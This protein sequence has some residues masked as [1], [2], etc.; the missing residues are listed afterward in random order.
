MISLGRFLPNWL[1]R[2]AALASSVAS[3]AS[4]WSL[5]AGGIE[6]QEIRWGPLSLFRA[7]PTLNLDHLSLQVGITLVAFTAI[8]VLSLRGARP[9]G[10]A[11]HGLI[12]IALSGSLVVVMAA[13]TLTA[14][15]GSALIDLAMLALAVSDSKDGRP[16]LASWKSVPGLL[17]TLF[18]FAAA[19]RMDSQVGTTSLL[20]RQFPTQVVAMVGLAGFLRLAVLFLHGGAIHR[21]EH[22]ATLILPFGVGLYLLV[23]TQAIAPV[24]AALPGWLTFAGLALLAGG[25]LAW[26]RG[27]ERDSLGYMWPGIVFHQAGLA[28]AF[29]I[30]L[31]GVMPWPLISMALATGIVAVWWDSGLEREPTSRSYVGQWLYR[32]VEPGW[33][34][35]RS[36][37]RERLPIAQRWPRFWWMPP[38]AAS[39]LWPTVALASLAGVPLTFGAVVRWRL[40]GSLLSQGKALL[41]LAILAADTLL[42]AALWTMLQV[43]HRQ[44]RQQRPRVGAVLAM[45]ALVVLLVALGIKPGAVE[46]L[47]P[48]TIARVS[49][50]GLGILFIL[51]WLAG[52]W[53]AYSTDQVRAAFDPLRKWAHVGRI[54]QGVVWAGQHFVGALYWLGAVGEGEG[55]LGWVLVILALSG[56]FLITR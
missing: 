37:V 34:R 1:A 6:S 56:L 25:W 47:K 11:W 3:F 44:A 20:Y 15:L 53:L 7:N 55:W 39:A 21:P 22:A 46:G 28:L 45:T 43:M 12:L 10:N 17:S 38:V 2:L 23:R 42:V 24:L 48:E 27:M 29:V 32:R 18:L 8:A 5:R 14:A 4:L 41:L 36:W 33:A 40:Y 19:L 52:S 54:R 26:Q 16:A 30:L 51:P 50:W 13:N 9:Q 35:V 31:P 49:P